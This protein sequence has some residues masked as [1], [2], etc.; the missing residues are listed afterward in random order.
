MQKS[1][2]G[3]LIILT[4]TPSG[5]GTTHSTHGIMLQ[6]IEGS[7]RCLI[8]NTE[9]TIA[10]SKRRS[11]TYEQKELPPCYIPNRG[12][13]TFRVVQTEITNDCERQIIKENFLWMFCR[14]KLNSNEAI[15]PGWKGWV[16]P[17]SKLNQETRT[18]LEYLPPINESIN[19]MATV[20]ETIEMAI[21]GSNEAGQEWTFITF[22]MAAAKK[23]YD[24]V[25]KQPDLYGKVIIHLGGF[26]TMLSYLAALGNFVRGSGFK[27]ITIE[28]GLCASGSLEQVMK[29]KH[30]N[31]CMRV[32][33]TM[34][35][36]LERML[37][38]AFLQNTGGA[39][40]EEEM[41]QIASGLKD[42][43]TCDK[44]D[45]VLSSPKFEEL[46]ANYEVYKQCV[47]IGT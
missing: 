17:T 23:A 32:H 14:C 19:N 26:H 9:A 39:P 37:F 36:A 6:E 21:A 44:A 27:E 13:P 42:T 8:Q 22:D 5:A 25:W 16:S 43:L 47:R 1:H 18:I 11:A 24:I 41:K 38:T 15:F 46:F 3:V 29:G 12:E 33:T 30:Y 31:R 2:T 45:E 40:T 34:T 10:R 20:K 4:E 28:A 35:E 7:E